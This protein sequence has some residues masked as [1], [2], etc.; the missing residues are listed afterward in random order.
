MSK[1]QME[2][3]EEMCQEQ[4]FSEDQMFRWQNFIE[5]VSKDAFTEGQESLT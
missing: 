4:G 3:F 5:Q 1:E 2:K